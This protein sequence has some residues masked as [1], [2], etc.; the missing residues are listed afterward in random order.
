MSDA[1][2]LQSIHNCAT[3]IICSMNKTEII[4]HQKSEPMPHVVVDIVQLLRLCNGILVN[5]SHV[6][7]SDA[8]IYVSK[9]T[10]SWMYNLCFHQQD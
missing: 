10:S 7:F 9:M 4:V 8:F 3:K 1:A 5:I 6:L 2:L